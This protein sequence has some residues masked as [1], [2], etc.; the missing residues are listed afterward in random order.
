MSYTPT[1][2]ATG[3][4]ITA[5]KLNKMEQGIAGIAGIFWV[6]WDNTNSRSVQTAAEVYA[7]VEQGA[8][9]IW[10]SGD[11]APFDYAYLLWVDTSL[12]PD[13]SVTYNFSFGNNTLVAYSDNDYLQFTD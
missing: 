10:K 9:V 7:A 11:A 1:E 5:E 3:D 4:V 2:W 12:Q 13:E 8:T 6:T